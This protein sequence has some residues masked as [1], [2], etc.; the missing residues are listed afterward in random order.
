MKLT[1]S[2]N[3]LN[4]TYADESGRIVYKVRTTGTIPGASTTIAKILPDDI[5][6][7]EDET[8]NGQEE[9]RFAHFARIDWKAYRVLVRG[10]EIPGKKLLRIEGWRRSRIFVGDDGKEYKWVL[11]PGHPELQLLD[12]IKETL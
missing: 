12:I 10:E 11:K 6:R 5:P 2:G 9:D 8:G 1:L 3:Y 4:S 7:R